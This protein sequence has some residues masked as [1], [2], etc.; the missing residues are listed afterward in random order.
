M[1][2]KRLLDI[3][4]SKHSLFLFGPRQ[5]GKTFLIKNTVPYDLFIDLLN[6]N[7]YMRYAR[8]TSILFNEVN[9]IKKGN[10]QVVI[11]EIQRCPN[12]LDTVQRTI[13][14][15]QGVKFIMTGSSA[16]KL[17]RTGVNLLGGRAITQHLHPFTYEEIK[18]YFVLEDALKYGSIPNIFLEKDKQ[19]KVRLLKSYVEIY[20][21]EEIQQES[22]T[23]NVPAFTFFLE[24]AANENGN[25]LNFQNIAREIGINSKTI[26][27]YFNILEDTLLGCSVHP[28]ARSHRARLVSHP[29]FYFFDTGVA[30]ALKGELFKDLVYGT[31]S[32]GKLFEHF[33]MLELKKI[34]DYREREIKLSFFR[35]NDGAEVDFILEF[36]D[37]IWAVEVKASNKPSLSGLSGLRSFMGDHKYARAMCVCQTPRPYKSENIE[38]LPWEDFISQI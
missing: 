36:H 24:L 20:L 16:R 11:D 6:Y 26:K 5:V 30:N 22:L 35:T 15:K 13:E 9:N 7:E 23:R 10:M 17:K 34:I 14:G 28:Y 1:I 38:F 29:K 2:I 12:L 4:K 33:I 27:E 21:K 3:N 8:D 37:K 18:D 31:A 19:E 25:I 32:Y